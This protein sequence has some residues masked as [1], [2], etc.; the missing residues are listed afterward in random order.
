MW[1]K[2][3]IIG[4]GVS[5][6]AAAYRLRRLAPDVVVRLWDARDRVGGVL[7]TIERDGCQL[8]LSADNFITTIPHGLDLCRELGL[9]SEVVP[10]QEAYRRTYVVRRGRLHL[11]PDGFLMMAP[12]RLVPMA[13]TPLLSPWGKLR[14]AMELLVPARRDDGDESLA[15]FVRRRFGREVFE[16]LVE[17]LVS[18]VYAAD[19]ERLSLMAT[20]PRFREMERDHGSLLWAMQRQ[21]WFRSPTSPPNSS[22]QHATARPAESGAR[23]S[24]FVTLRRGLS[25]LTDA[26]AATLAPESVHLQRTATRL[27]RDNGLW[28]ATDQRG[29]AESFDAVILA[30]SA[31]AAAGLLSPS[32]PRLADLLRPIEYEGTAIVTLAFRAT[33]IQRRLVG[34]GFVVPQIE[35]SP[36]LA[37]SFSSLKYAHRAPDGMF[38]VRLFAGGARHPA[39]ATM[40]AAELV[41]LVTGALAPLLAIDGEPLWTNVSHW[42]ATM[43][44]YHLGHRERVAAM[45]PLWES[46]PSSLALCGS[47]LGGVGIPQCIQS[48]N[49]AA[50]HIRECLAIP[51]AG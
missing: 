27:V 34:M 21:R 19:M 23:Y 2:C 49:A 6:L 48:G 39:L 33:Q 36:I 37:G 5:G 3:L 14:A 41:P 7:E 50:E 10:T 38:L 28:T 17:P 44:Q 4:G 11:L 51:S 32:L 46:C 15:H 43:P 31:T 26:L 12:T 20:L 40:P 8:E 35:G 16:R 30:T 42:P 22:T 13:L 9:E 25:S 18:G 47:Y 45:R 24:L 1:K 29:Q